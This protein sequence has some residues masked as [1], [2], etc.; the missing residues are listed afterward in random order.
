MRP[1]GWLA[2]ISAVG[3][4]AAGCGGGPSAPGAAT[5]IA[6]AKPPAAPKAAAK[7]L[8]PAVKPKVV[9]PGPPLPPL[10]YE[11]KGRRDPF[12]PIELPKDRPGLDVSSLRLVGII[13]GRHL[14][15]LVETPGGLGYILKPGDALGNGH[16]SEIAPGSVTFAVSGSRSQREARVT[17]PLGRD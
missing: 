7:P 9:E 17:L 12:V 11:A 16:V 4:L 6:V 10:A 13:S 1:L 2:W 5:R 14:L 8:L 3:F 15:A